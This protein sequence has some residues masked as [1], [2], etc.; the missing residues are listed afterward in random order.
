MK[1]V[2]IIAGDKSGD[3]YGGYLSKELNEDTDIKIYSFGGDN[4]ARHSEQIIDLLQFS[5]C[6][7]TEVLSYLRRIRLI[8]NRTV[9]AIHS[10]KPDLIILIDF[11][12]F[13]L[14]LARKLNNRYNI[15]YY[16]SP[17]VWAW[18]KG[19]IKL[20]REYV[21]KII[22]IFK[23]EKDFYAEQNVKV[24]YFGH[25][26]L[27]IIEDKVE[28]GKRSEKI[29]SFLPGSRINE[30][31]KHLPVFK[32]AMYLIKKEL[33]GYKYRIIKPAHLQEKIYKEL[34]GNEEI[35]PHSYS[36]INESEFVISSSGTATIEIAI[37]GIPYI[38]VYKMNYLT[39][40]ILRRMVK[41]RFIS[42]V[43]LLRSKKVI[44]ELI[45][46]DV[47]PRN[48]CR[49]TVNYLLH[50]DKYEALKKDILE[51]KKLLEPRGA[52]KRFADF[53]RGYLKEK[54]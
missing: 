51:T 26:L 44:D 11:P 47:T 33:P 45:Q 21:R 4:L 23:F 3:L 52:V 36:A 27:D 46:K 20:L 29:I 7:I 13:N 35:I 31:K 34:C 39:W 38:I 1:K 37:L 19:R 16:I 54:G 15:F 41:V 50:K 9:E 53:I 30:V 25:P 24:L 32:K 42:M 43:N 18:R 10:I 14:R 22:V 40:H 28:T 12:D 8:F 48:I 49:K 5:I 17:Q 6:G 2:V